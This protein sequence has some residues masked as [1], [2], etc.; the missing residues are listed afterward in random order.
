MKPAQLPVPKPLQPV[1]PAQPSKPFGGTLGTVLL[2]FGIG[3]LGAFMLDLHGHQCMA[4]GYRWRHLG[5]FNV[6]DLAAHT[7]RRCGETQWW[8]DGVVD[9]HG[10]FRPLPGADVLGRPLPATLTSLGGPPKR[11]GT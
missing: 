3:A 10:A 5:A 4:C 9:G 8:K 1:Q 11:E 2:A 7:C 6:G